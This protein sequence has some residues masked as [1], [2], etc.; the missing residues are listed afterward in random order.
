[1]LQRG[2]ARLDR[3]DPQPGWDAP[4]PGEPP[5]YFLRAA[6][7]VATVIIANGRWRR[8]PGLTVSLSQILVFGLAMASCAA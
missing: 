3:V 1:M 8:L 4:I 2:I 7:T 5:F 6:L